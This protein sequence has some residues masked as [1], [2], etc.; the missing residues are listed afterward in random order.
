MS[1]NLINEAIHDPYSTDREYTSKQPNGRLRYQPFSLSYGSEERHSSGA[2]GGSE[3]IGGEE[4]K[5][6]Q[7]Q[8][9]EE[10]LARPSHQVS[11]VSF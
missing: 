11:N 7:H 6:E 5:V 1:L 2:A 3:R 9:A 10:Q 4:G 8:T